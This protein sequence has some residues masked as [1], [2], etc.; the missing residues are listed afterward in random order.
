MG[1]VFMRLWK[2]PGQAGAK[3]GDGRVS[4]FS[5]TSLAFNQPAHSWRCGS[6]CRGS[7]SHGHRHHFRQQHPRPRLWAERWGWRMG[8]GTDLTSGSFQVAGGTGAGH[9]VP[10]RAAMCQPCASGVRQNGGGASDPVWKG[11]EGLLEEEMSFEG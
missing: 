8:Q 4:Q 7:Q 9:A 5:K 11:K 6:G 10:S 1:Q 2:L 3:V